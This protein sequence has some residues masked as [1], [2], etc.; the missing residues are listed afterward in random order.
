MAEPS[1]TMNDAAHELTYAHFI[2]MVKFAMAAL[3]FAVVALYSFIIAG[4][5]W[6]G[7]V[8]LILAVPA[9]LGDNRLGKAKS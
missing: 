9:G 7:L 2:A 8:L 1:E 6:L 5:F 3:A 4:N